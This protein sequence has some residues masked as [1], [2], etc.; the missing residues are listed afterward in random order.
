MPLKEARNLHVVWMK[1][2]YNI[3]CNVFKISSLQEVSDV[4]D[5]RSLRW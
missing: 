4:I 3:L 2:K 5:P 1:R